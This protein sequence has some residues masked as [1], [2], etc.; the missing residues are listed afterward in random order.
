MSDTLAGKYKLLFRVHSAGRMFEP[1]S[2]VDLS[3]EDA[4]TMLELKGAE[5]V[6][7]EAPAAPETQPD[8]AANAAAEAVAKTNELTLVAAPAAEANPPPPKGDRKQK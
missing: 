4:A 6:A 7:D 3:H 5:R 2:V 8:D 1:G